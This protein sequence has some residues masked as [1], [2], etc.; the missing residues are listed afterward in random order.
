MPDI[1]SEFTDVVVDLET[2]GT[3]PGCAI[4]SIGAV[5]LNEFGV[6]TVGFYRAIEIPD[7]DTSGLTPDGLH[8]DEHTIEWWK[9]QS[10][11]ALKVFHEGRLTTR[12]AISDLASYIASLGK[13]R[14]W[15]N[16]ADF[17]NA[18]IAV[19]AHTVGIKPKDVWGSYDGRCYRTVKNQYK[20]I[21]LVREGTYHNALD[22]ARSQAAHLVT[23]CQRRGWRLA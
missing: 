13:P 5:A 14:V 9:G 4:V 6:D 3:V 12:Q 2:L 7:W 15:G 10:P 1:N 22:D 18:I 16:G 19:A 11:A 21:K 8:K 17:D 20:N 23:I